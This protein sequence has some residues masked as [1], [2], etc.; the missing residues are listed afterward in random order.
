MDVQN[1]A[2][3]PVAES[4]AA[5]TQQAPTEGAKPN[6]EAHAKEETNQESSQGQESGSQGQEDAG[7][8]QVNRF[9][10]GLEKMQAQMRELRKKEEEVKGNEEAIKLYRRIEEAR[11]TGNPDA[12]LL[13][14]GITP[15]PK[16]Q[17]EP[18]LLER[19]FAPERQEDETV[20]EH[21]RRLQA[22]LDAIKKELG[23]YRGAQEEMKKVREREDQQRY[24]DYLLN[25]F[26]ESYKK[27]A[28]RFQLVNASDHLGAARSA[29]GIYSN[30]ASMGGVTPSVDET[31]EQLENYFED[32]MDSFQNTPKFNNRV[33]QYV[34]KKYGVTLQDKRN[35][36]DNKRQALTN[37]LVGE[38]ATEMGPSSSDK[39]ARN[40]ALAKAMAIREQIMK[41]EQN[42][43]NNK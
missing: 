3:T 29:F 15:P 6:G 24:E 28:D 14:A 11:K 38:S 40:K 39:E 35:D 9:Q 20:P 33:L 42:L 19:L 26:K 23:G 31:N 32:L 21:T 17:K 36:A 30:L 13:A 37:N 4:S 43:L 5:G 22:E 41:E 25:Q 8:L 16:Q 7:E 10:K 2:T 34:K 1:Q 12:V 27:N 18:D